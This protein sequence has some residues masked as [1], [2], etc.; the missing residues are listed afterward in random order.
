L[1]FSLVVGF[2][3][4]LPVATGAKTVQPDL[5]RADWSANAPNSL[6]DNPPSK[7]AVWS[8]IGQRLG[9]FADLG[10]KLCDFRFVDLR[11][12]GTLSLVV[13]DDAGGTADCSVVEVFDKGPDGIEEYYDG[14]YLATPG[15][16]DINGDGRFEVVVD[17]P[18]GVKYRDGAKFYHGSEIAH[19][20]GCR[21][22]NEIWPRVYAWTGSGYTE[23]S[24]Q[25]PEFYKRE[26][27]S[28]KKRIAAIDA[29]EPTTQLSPSVDSSSPQS[30]P[31]PL[32]MK[33]HWPSTLE[34]PQTADV[35][36]SQ[37][38][39]P[40]PPVASA[41]SEATHAR[42]AEDWDC[43]KAEEAK[44]E[45]FLGISKD[46]GMGDAIRWANSNSPAEREF[47]TAILPQIR[48]A[49]ALEY[50]QTL[51][52]DSDHDVAVS[53]KSGVKHWREPEKSAS[54]FERLPNQP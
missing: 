28:L 47:A 27:K 49:E 21:A 50:E 41:T 34:R 45:R 37:E 11:R 17:E 33:A 1:I 36:Q 38:A 44:M 29:S 13:V 35:Q 48:T 46:A 39:Q 23:V 25:F 5:G 42:E 20:D 51:S 6:A 9:S 31:T 14:G 7:E 53:A 22:C 12:R 8:F 16:E 52:R 19:C 24:S 32:E 15:V 26:L 40:E 4:G 54:A 10:G 30:A 43:L 2:L 18:D 3:L